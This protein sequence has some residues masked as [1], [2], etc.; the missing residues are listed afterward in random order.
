VDEIGKGLSPRAA[1]LLDAAYRHVLKHGLADLS[2]RPLAA[3]IGSS[4]RVLLFLFGS[5][6]GLVRALL[7]KAR[8]D[9]L[10]VLDQLA[11]TAHPARV[12]AVWEWL[13]DPAHRSFLTLWVEAYGRSL[14]DPA[15]PWGDFA[16]RT[17]DDWL[18]LLASAPDPTL[19][20]SV[21]R[22]ALLDLLATGDTARTTKAVEDYCASILMGEPS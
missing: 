2:L 18:T 4:P 15:G 8:A 6:D 3:A 21:L 13:A 16:Q 5:K 1:E 7:A 11:D 12:R 22:G 9:E 20:L 10:A 19:A 17:V 14:I